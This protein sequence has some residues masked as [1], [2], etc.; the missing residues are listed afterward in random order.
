MTGQSEGDIRHQNDTT[1]DIKQV[2]DKW[3]LDRWK[4]TCERLNP[5]T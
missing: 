4:T 3:K 2:L 5:E 1:E